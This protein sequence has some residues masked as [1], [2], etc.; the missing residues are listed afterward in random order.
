[1]KMI[2]QDKRKNVVN[3][4]IKDYK[5]IIP[6]IKIFNNFLYNIIVYFIFFNLI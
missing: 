1:M 4:R 3:I 2:D 5:I 6:K